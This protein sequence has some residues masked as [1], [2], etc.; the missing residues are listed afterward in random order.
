MKR[1][2]IVSLTRQNLEKN[3]KTAK[4]PF[5][6]LAVSIILTLGITYLFYQSAR[7]KDSIRFNNEVNRLQLTIENKINLYVALLKGGRG[8]I[9]SNRSITRENF[10]EYVESLDL[11]KNY[12]GVQGIG[13]AQVVAAGEQA[14]QAQAADDNV[15]DAEVKEVKKG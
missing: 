15:V 13:Y 5:L 2:F 7:T 4:F 9:E 8:F 3:D 11:G 14:A 12:M 10:A 6:V 1:F